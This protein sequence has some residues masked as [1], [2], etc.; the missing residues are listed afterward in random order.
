MPNFIST[1]SLDFFLV[2]SIMLASTTKGDTLEYEVKKKFEEMNIKIQGI[3]TSYQTE[4]GTEDGGIFVT[5]ISYLPSTIAAASKLSCIINYSNLSNVVKDILIKGR[6]HF[7]TIEKIV[8]NLQS[9]SL[10]YFTKE[11]ELDIN[12]HVNIIMNISQR[13]LILILIT[14][15]ILIFTFSTGLI[16]AEIGIFLG[17]L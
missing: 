17:N 14:F 15:E 3:K 4:K 16:L 6:I 9:V 10:E 1:P 5:T 2:F 8:Q 12:M 7:I 11:I 13:K